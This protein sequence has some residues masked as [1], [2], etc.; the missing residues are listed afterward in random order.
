MHHIFDW[1]YVCHVLLYCIL[2]SFIACA[3][4]ESTRQ[5]DTE[6]FKATMGCLILSQKNKMTLPDR[7]TQSKENPSS[8]NSCRV[9]TGS[10]GSSDQ[11]EEVEVDILVYSP[12]A[13]AKAWEEGLTVPEFTTEEEMEEEENEIDVI[14][15]Q[16]D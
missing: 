8:K 15:Y 5:E 11:E 9:T 12:C 2:Y 13:Q 7:Q 16:T 1:K 6:G 3:A 10:T 14:G 4:S